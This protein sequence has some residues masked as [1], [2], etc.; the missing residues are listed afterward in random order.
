MKTTNLAGRGMTCWKNTTHYLDLLRL[1]KTLDNSKPL[2]MANLQQGQLSIVFFTSSVGRLECDITPGWHHERAAQCR[3]LVGRKGREGKEG[4]SRLF[5][6]SHQAAV[7]SCCAP[8]LYCR[9]PAC[10]SHPT[11]QLTRILSR[12]SPLSHLHKLKLVGRLCVLLALCP[13]ISEIS[14]IGLHWLVSQW[15]LR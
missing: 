13:Y 9:P 3:G 8:S 10:T 5:L 1:S 11:H 4:I 7:P 12:I 2:N 14:F 6:F 15:Y